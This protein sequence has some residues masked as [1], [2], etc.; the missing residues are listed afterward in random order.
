M[1]TVKNGISDRIQNQPRHRNYKRLLSLYL[2]RGIG[3]S[4]ITR[5]QSVFYQS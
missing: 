5:L 4:T 1:S 2:Q 3:H